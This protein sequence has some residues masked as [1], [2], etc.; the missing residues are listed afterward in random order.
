MPFTPTDEK[1]H[2]CDETRIQDEVNALEQYEYEMRK[3]AISIP[4]GLREFRSRHGLSQE[5]M[6]KLMQVSKRSYLDYERGERSVPSAAL[7]E[8]VAR[9]DLDLNELFRGNPLAVPV[10][11]KQDFYRFSKAV[12]QVIYELEPDIDKKTFGETTDRYLASFEPDDPIDRSM[13]AD[14]IC[15]IHYRNFRDAID[16]EENNQ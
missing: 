14:I 7:V 11:Y 10:K 5:Q 3:Q 8:L 13:L 1:K 15:S 12:E 6:A 2:D 4:K 9:T 16:S